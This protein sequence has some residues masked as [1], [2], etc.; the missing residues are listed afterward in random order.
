MPRRDFGWL[1]FVF[2][3]GLIVMGLAIILWAVNV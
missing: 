1:D 3:A 2:W